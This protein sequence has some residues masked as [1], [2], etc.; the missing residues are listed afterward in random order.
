MPA[1]L[2]V[3]P[4]SVT[5]SGFADGLG[6]RSIRFDRE[7]GTTLEC[8][9]VRPEL[10][11]FEQ[12]LRAQAQVLNALDDERFVRVRA[13]ERIE[14]RLDVISE[15]LAGDRLSDIIDARATGESAVSGIDAAFGFLLQILPALAAMHAASIVHGALAPG[16]IVVTTSAQIVIADAIYGSALPR[17]NLSRTRLWQELGVAAP[18]SAEVVRLDASSDVAQAALTAL[19]LALGRGVTGVDPAASLAPL[20]REVAEIAQ[21]RGGD[22]LAESVRGFFASTLP[23]AGR[24]SEQTA[25]QAAAEVRT[26]ANRQLGE[27]TCLSA[28]AD[29]A[30]YDV[31]DD[32]VP[33]VR[34]RVPPPVAV[35]VAVPLPVVAEAPAPL[36]VA[37]APAPLVVVGAPVPQPVVAQTPA[38]LA[39]AVP[40][41]LSVAVQAPDVQPAP[42]AFRAPT[43]LVVP[44]TRPLVAREAAQRPVAPAPDTTLRI[45]AEPPAGY[46][47]PRTTRT[48]EAD[49]PIEARRFP[50]KAA[51]A[52]AIL[53]VG[54][55]GG[56]GYLLGPGVTVAPPLARTSAPPPPVSASA[57]LPR[58]A[59]NVTSQP[60]GARVLLDGTDAGQTPLRLDG[61]EVG[62]HTIT[63]VTDTMSVKRTVRVEAGKTAA[64]DVPVFSGWVTV[65]A[66][67]VLDVAEA[68]RTLG[69]T[70]QRRILL[71][72]GRHTLTLT[73]R[74]FG[75]SS[76]QKVDIVAG[77][78][79]AL[80]LTP[81]GV[82]N[83][84]AQP[85][86]EVWIDGARAGETPLANLQVALGIRE[87]VFKH[88]QYGERRVTTTITSTTSVLSVDLTKPSFLP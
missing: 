3:R 20:V 1:A 36:A 11:A 14:G 50:W 52:V 23:M 22:S 61:V 62:R 73:H 24:R 75:Y 48:L 38:P 31:Q 55:L 7:C 77:E 4:P 42:I 82:I 70:E 63:L 57:P 56:R 26:I 21:I 65:F 32:P 30:R 84:N 40:T 83:L 59:L 8:L 67:I 88:P 25:E 60:T 76:V 16:R 74:E 5:T 79:R 6:R 10:A 34:V 71:S 43:P 58:G 49:S 81:T 27:D 54:V 64:L 39:V 51:A 45:K 68:G 66:P 13:F 47:P 78:E 85:W 72:P 29:F 87:F 44:M 15:L 9:H 46:A 53:T 80:N 41:P 17:L 35:V 2:D 37:E 86:A 28:L 69:T 18:L 12:A 19:T 33:A